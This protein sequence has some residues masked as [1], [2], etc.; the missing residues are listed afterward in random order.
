MSAGRNSAHT[1]SSSK[2]RFSGTSLLDS[3]LSTARRPPQGE[4]ALRG[5]SCC[6]EDP[7]A[8]EL[9]VSTRDWQKEKH[10]FS[11]SRTPPLHMP[12]RKHMR[13]RPSRNGWHIWMPRREAGHRSSMWPREGR[14]V[15]AQEIVLSRRCRPEFPLRSSSPPPPASHPWPR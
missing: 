3:S 12:S 8:E 6:K 1:A 15:V 11:T 5:R 10:V 13:S 4:V 14:P 9:Y 7:V 2:R